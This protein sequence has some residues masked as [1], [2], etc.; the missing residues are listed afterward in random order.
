LQQHA[1]DATGTRHGEQSSPF[2]DNPY[3]I[4]FAMPNTQRL[5][6]SIGLGHRAE[7]PRLDL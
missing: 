3:D 5:M 4:P 6:G 1:S 7:N 2:P